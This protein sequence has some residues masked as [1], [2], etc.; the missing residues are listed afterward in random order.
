MFSLLRTEVLNDGARLWEAL[1][2]ELVPKGVATYILTSVALSEGQHSD[3]MAEGWEFR[4]RKLEE[5]RE[6]CGVE[7]SDDLDFVVGLM[8]EG[9]LGEEFDGL[10]EV[11]LGM[12]EEELRKEN[13]V[14]MVEGWVLEG[15]R[16]K[17]G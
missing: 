2:E 6:Y 10:K 8:V 16:E 5:E 12:K 3:E 1:E 9:V 11:W 7:S 14:W 4:R 17:E 15:V 13:V